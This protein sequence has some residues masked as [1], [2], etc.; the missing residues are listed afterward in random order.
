MTHNHTTSAHRVEWAA[1]ITA[2][3]LTLVYKFCKYLYD[4]RR[5]WMNAHGGG[6]NSG[7]VLKPWPM[8]RAVFGWFFEGSADNAVSWITTIGVV[9][10][11]GYLY[12]S[13]SL[14]DS[15]PVHPSIAFLFGSLA[16]MTAPEVSKY[17]ASK[18]VPM[19][20]RVFGGKKEP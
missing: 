17:I 1:Y 8:R 15:V 11:G 2:A 5:I 19:L 16:E 6:E 13:S 14:M 12:L 7:D 20:E 10:V 3:V 9:W 18:A 4:N